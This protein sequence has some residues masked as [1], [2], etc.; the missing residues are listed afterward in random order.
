LPPLRILVVWDNLAGHH[1][2]AIVDWC[3]QQ[4]ILPLSTP[5]AG[6]WLTMAESLQRILVRRALAGQ[7]PETAQQVMDWLAQAVRGWNANPT[8]FE[9]GGK[10][11]ARR[12]RARARRHALGGA[13]A[14]TRRPVRRTDGLPA[15]AAN[16][17]I[18]GN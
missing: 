14:C 15:L 18:H 3:V 10:R 4:G 7:H 9:W 2:P 12:Q 5:V 1:S 16:G 13:G 11:A 17:N 8:P 6:S